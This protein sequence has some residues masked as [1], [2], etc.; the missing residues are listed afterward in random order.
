MARKREPEETITKFALARFIDQELQSYALSTLLI[1][2]LWAMADKVGCVQI[3]DLELG[4]LAATV[5]QERP[6]D[7]GR[8]I[9]DMV[10]RGDLAKLGTKRWQLKAIE[11]LLGKPR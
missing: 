1:V 8:R 9:E 6:H 11:H 5:C 10:E 4:A 2:R 7:A 3:S